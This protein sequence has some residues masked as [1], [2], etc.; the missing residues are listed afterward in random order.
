MTNQIDH[1]RFYLD[2]YKSMKQAAIEAI[3]NY[4]K[5]L[6]I[7]EACKLMY[8]KQQHYKTD[9][10]IPED[11]LLDFIQFNTYSCVFCGKHEDLYPVNIMKVRYDES[12]KD[13]EVYLESDEGYI[14][15]W[16]PV[17]WISYEEAAVYMSI[18]DFLKPHE[19]ETKP[20]IYDNHFGFIDEKIDFRLV[21]IPELNADVEVTTTDV[22]KKYG[23]KIDDFFACYVEPEIFYNLPDK[24]FEDYVNKEFYC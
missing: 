7:R 18:L 6:D 17:S 22:F 1:V 13:I 15:D 3:K 19:Q 23:D 14:A 9:D 10:E 5:E 20:T 11:E 16:Y 12:S 24:E 8:M 2:A 4:G 21:F